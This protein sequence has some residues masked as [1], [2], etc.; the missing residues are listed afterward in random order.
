MDT[1]LVEHLGR[2]HLIGQLLRAGLEVALPIRDRGIDVIAYADIDRRIAKFVA[3]PI[4]LKVAS[5]RNFSL[6]L[7]Y[8]RVRNLL[9][10]YVWNVQGDATPTIYALDYREA[11]ALATK[12]GW[13]K[14]ASWKRGR[15]ATTRP[16]RRIVDLLQ[17]YRMTP[18]RWWERVACK[19]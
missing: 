10:A 12:V 14:T 11:K 7:K 4:Q 6:D 2:Q 8:A 5:Q 18:E 1:Q 9:I 19:K 17:K 15:Y 13:T 16:S 3:C